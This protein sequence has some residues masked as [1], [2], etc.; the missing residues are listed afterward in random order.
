MGRRVSGWEDIDEAEEKSLGRSRLASLRIRVLECG[1]MKVSRCP[2]VSDAARILLVGKK[3]SFV[4][5]RGYVPKVPASTQGGRL[6]CFWRVL[7]AV[8]ISRALQLEYGSLG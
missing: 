4:M 5:V 3:I 6:E 1:R 7:A 8:M 2:L